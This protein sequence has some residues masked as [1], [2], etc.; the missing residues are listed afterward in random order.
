MC[1]SLVDIIFDVKEGQQSFE[2]IIS[3]YEVHELEL[4][5]MRVLGKTHRNK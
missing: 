5:N 4:D 3:D 1:R 2:K